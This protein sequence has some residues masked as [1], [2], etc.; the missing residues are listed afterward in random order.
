M[1]IKTILVTGLLSLSLAANAAP[2]TVLGYTFDDA[3]VNV[4]SG[5]TVDYDTKHPAH[6][7]YNSFPASDPD[8]P[9]AID[10]ALDFIGTTTNSNAYFDSDT[11][12]PHDVDASVT[13]FLNY[14]GNEYPFHNITPPVIT[15]DVFQG[16]NDTP[17]GTFLEFSTVSTGV[18]ELQLTV[19]GGAAAEYF[20]GGTM[21]YNET[22]LIQ[23]WDSGNGNVFFEYFDD[24]NFTLTMTATPVSAVPV[25]A[26]V[27]LFGSG[28][29][30]MIAIGRR[31][32]A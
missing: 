1:S 7:G 30:G 20:T 3:G 19:T 12:N 18:G 22:L 27:W 15:F 14:G 24:P 21:L 32:N 8:E 29:L 5:L 13:G 11:N 9:Y 25:P 10:G 23:E 6:P 26:A 2:V 28:L 4:F 31:R 16:E 17:L